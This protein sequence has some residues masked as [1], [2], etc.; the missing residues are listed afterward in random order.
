MDLVKEVNRGSSVVRVEL[1][2]HRKMFV[3]KRGEGKGEVN[4]G[5]KKYRAMETS[6]SIV[7]R[8]AVDLVVLI[9]FSL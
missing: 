8:A 3:F 1:A 6:S 9:Q 7:R 4:R 2:Q 5:T